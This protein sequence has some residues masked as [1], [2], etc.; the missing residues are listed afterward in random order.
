[1]KTMDIYKANN[2]MRLLCGKTSIPCQN[3]TAQGVR[4][5]QSTGRSEQDPK[6]RKNSAI[7]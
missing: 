2:T 6:K 1:M 7:L 5:I 4:G 3:V